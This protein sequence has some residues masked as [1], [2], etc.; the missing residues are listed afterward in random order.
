M[1]SRISTNSTPESNYLQLPRIDLR[2]E[3]Y[4]HRF[5]EVKHCDQSTSARSSSL[6]NISRLDQSEV[7]IAPTSGHP[8]RKRLDRFQQNELNR[9]QNCLEKT[10][11]VY[12]S[13]EAF[14]KAFFNP[15][16]ANRE[17]LLDELKK[18]DELRRKNLYHH[19]LK[20][21]KRSSSKNSK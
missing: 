4:Y 19:N 16:D 8:N 21:K 3:K 1:K 7:I 10:K 2:P 12:E 6:N 11:G 13:E 14:K 15:P 5:N 17:T 18:R 9:F 20:K